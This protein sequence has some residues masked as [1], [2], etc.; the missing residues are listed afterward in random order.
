MCFWARR[1][2][3]NTADRR[4]RPARAYTQLIPSRSDGAVVQSLNGLEEG[5]ELNRSLVKRSDDMMGG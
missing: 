1:G 5:A 4:A 2:H 3:Y